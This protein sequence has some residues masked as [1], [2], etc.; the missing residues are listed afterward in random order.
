[1]VPLVQ[2]YCVHQIVYHAH[3]MRVLDIYKENI[4]T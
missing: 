2:W 1:M 4:P 3:D